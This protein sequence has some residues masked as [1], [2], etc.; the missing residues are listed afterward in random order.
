MLRA[1]RAANTITGDDRTR[2]SVTPVEKSVGK[3]A[4]KGILK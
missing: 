1:V 2:L 4:R 3:L